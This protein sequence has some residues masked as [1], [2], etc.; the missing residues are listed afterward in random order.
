MLLSK[1]V[2]TA[3]VLCSSLASSVAAESRQVDAVLE[4]FTPQGC[5]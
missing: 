3:V 5:S 2:I 4:L 1:P